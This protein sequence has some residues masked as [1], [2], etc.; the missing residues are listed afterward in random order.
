MA[1]VFGESLFNE[2]VTAFSGIDAT[3]ITATDIISGSIATDSLLTNTISVNSGIITA[4]SFVRV[5]GSSTQFL[6]ADGSIDPNTYLTFVTSPIPAGSLMLFQQTT[7]PTGWTK[8]TTHHDKALRVVTGTASTGGT[9]SF[10]SVMTSRTP[11]GSNSGGSV[12]N[13]TL[14]ASQLGNHTHYYVAPSSYNARG[15]YGYSKSDGLVF[16]SGAG[17]NSGGINEG[18]GGAHNHGFTNP[19]FTGNVMDFAVNYVDLI[20]ASK[21]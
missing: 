12:S 18:S 4:N 11:T 8:Q 5:G 10:S 7:A 20:I 9:T 6:K 3:N 19:S 15:S 16:P 13:T 21:T 17:A 1:E 14:T 2:K